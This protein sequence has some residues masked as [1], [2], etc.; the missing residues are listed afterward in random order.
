[1]IFSQLHKTR[2]INAVFMLRENLFF[3]FWYIT[4]SNK[5]LFFSDETVI[6]FM[7]DGVLLKEIEKVFY[8]LIV[9]KFKGLAFIHVIFCEFSPSITTVF[10]IYSLL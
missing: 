10:Q 4:C 1:M 6:K 8:Y 7:T 3:L 2:A 9:V 5:F